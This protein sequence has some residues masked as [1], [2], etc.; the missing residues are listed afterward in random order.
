VQKT[1]YKQISA[2]GLLAV[3]WRGTILFSPP[4]TCMMTPEGCSGGK[5]LHECRRKMLREKE[6]WEGEIPLILGWT[7]A[8]I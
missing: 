6:M 3:D 8:A 2:L 4:I 5:N 1:T 7:I